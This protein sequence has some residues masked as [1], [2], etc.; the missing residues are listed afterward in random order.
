V[1][2]DGYRSGSG[3]HPRRGR[4]LGGDGRDGRRRRG[5]DDRAA[6]HV[7]RFAVRRWRPRSVNRTNLS[8]AAR[9]ATVADRRRP[10]SRP[11]A[12]RLAGSP[13]LELRNS[14]SRQSG[15][16][17]MDARCV[18]RV[19]H[20][21]VR[22]G[23]SQRPDD[24]RLGDVD[25]L[26]SRPN[27]RAA[28]R[29]P[30]SASVATWHL[31]FPLAICQFQSPPSPVGRRDR[32]VLAGAGR[33]GRGRFSSWLDGAARYNARPGFCS[34]DSEARVSRRSGI[35][36]EESAAG[37][38]RTG[39]RS[40][41]GLLAPCLPPTAIGDRQHFDEPQARA[42]AG[43]QRTRPWSCQPPRP[44]RGPPRSH[45]ELPD[46]E[47]T[48]GA[49]QVAPHGPGQVSPSSATRPAPPGRPSLCH[50]RPPGQGA[51]SV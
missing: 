31:L 22:S 51:S 42:T 10:S 29:C 11:A 41:P 38:A 20:Q 40:A 19:V 9:V 28:S 33:R 7:T 47:A 5:R 16:R 24:D 35:V 46:C 43:C 8:A 37:L 2:R 26:P 17:P 4:R 14:A 21:R 27:S 48:G 50:A 45:S 49:R 23:R 13:V 15:D 36:P 25:S 12:Q 6:A 34:S 44:A 32:A 3:C 30:A 1:R 18:R 39:H